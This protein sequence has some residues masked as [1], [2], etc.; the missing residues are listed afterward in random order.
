MVPLKGIITRSSSLSALE[1]LIF[2]TNT[3]SALIMTPSNLL[4]G[5]TLTVYLIIIYLISALKEE[6]NEVFCELFHMFV[7]LLLKNVS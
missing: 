5:E 2:G 3:R 6:V 4:R 1:L 7:N